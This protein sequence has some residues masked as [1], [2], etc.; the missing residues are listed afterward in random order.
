MGVIGGSSISAVLPVHVTGRALDWC[1]RETSNWNW[2]P[3]SNQIAV[4]RAIRCSLWQSIFSSTLPPYLDLG[5]APGFQP[6]A[7]V[8]NKDSLDKS[9]YTSLDYPIR[10]NYS[11]TLPGEPD[12]SQTPLIHESHLCLQL[13][14]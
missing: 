11:T 1:E 3:Y 7:A 8:A 14:V 2:S 5:T 13:E 10:V 6:E 12:A 9:F 4:S